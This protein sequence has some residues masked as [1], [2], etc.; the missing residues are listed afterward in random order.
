M[1]ENNYIKKYAEI[2]SKQEE[3][4]F[5]FNNN[6]NQVSAIKS[7]KQIGFCE[8][9]DLHNKSIPSDAIDANIT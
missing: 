9:D 4:K 7:V 8:K 2:N 3:E 6:P 5:Y 1:Y